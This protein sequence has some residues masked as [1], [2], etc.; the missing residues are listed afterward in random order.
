MVKNR[1]GFFE[2]QILVFG[3]YHS[4]VG[5]KTLVRIGLEVFG[6]ILERALPGTHSPNRGDA[7][8]AKIEHPVR[9]I[10]STLSVKVEQCVRLN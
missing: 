3:I 6:F 4:H 10:L 2:N 7:Y 1:N 5:V 8:S 9:L